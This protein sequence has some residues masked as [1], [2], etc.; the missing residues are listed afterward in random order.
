MDKVFGSFVKLT[1]YIPQK[2]AFRTKIYYEDKNI[3]NRKIKGP[4]II[5]SN[6]K[7]VWDF[8]TN[9]FTFWGR[10]LRCV[11]AD[12]TG[13]K[14]WFMKQFMRWLG[15]IVINRESLELGFID[16]SVKI[17]KDG[18]VL[19]LFPE[20]RL[21]LPS[22]KD[23]ELLPFT[24]SAAYIAYLANAKIIPVY[25]TGKYFKKERN[26]IIIGTPINVGDMFDKSVDEKTN[27]TN[28]TNALQE[29][30]L[31]LKHELEEKTKK[32]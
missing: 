2:L 23:K 16:Q 29:K 9:M 24:T 19:E 17:L 5:V 8:A 4:A 30:I 18:G 27:L 20:T 7:D 31:K 3:Q 28:I 13:H 10:N 6:H 22:E 1:G 14:N 11:V 21:P 25:T 15:N 12:V 32:V 26:R